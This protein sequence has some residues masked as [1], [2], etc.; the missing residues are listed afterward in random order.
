M[1]SRAVLL[2]SQLVILLASTLSHMEGQSSWLAVC[3]CETDWPKAITRA[4]GR[5]VVEWKSRGRE[6]RRRDRKE[7]RYCRAE[8]DGRG[9][10]Y[11]P[12]GTVS[13]S[14]WSSLYLLSSCWANTSE[15]QL[16]STLLGLHPKAF[17]KQP[18]K[19]NVPGIINLYRY[20]SE[21]RLSSNQLY[22]HQLSLNNCESLLVKLPC[23]LILCRFTIGIEITETHVPKSSNQA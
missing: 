13:M 5:E 4:V 17:T 22:E 6:I 23:A 11:L 14:K 10:A 19:L 18:F 2:G 3:P 8:D 16:P 15:M 21:K 7:R 12:S 1:F 9:M 20:L